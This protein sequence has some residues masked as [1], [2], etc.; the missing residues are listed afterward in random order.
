MQVNNKSKAAFHW[1]SFLIN[2]SFNFHFHCLL[3]CTRFCL[4]G[5]IS[6]KP[7]KKTQERFRVRNWKCVSDHRPRPP[8]ALS[9]STVVLLQSKLQQVSRVSDDDGLSLLVVSVFDGALRAV[10][11]ATAWLQHF[12]RFTAAKVDVG[13][14]RC[15][16]DRILPLVSANQCPWQSGLPGGLLIL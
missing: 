5:C 6:I 4:V 16:L 10:S 9:A 11:A 12:A 2:S 13:R 8:S 7:K 1:T 15:P 3:V 14:S